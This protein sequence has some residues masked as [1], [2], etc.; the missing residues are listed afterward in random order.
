L[1]GFDNVFLTAFI[2]Q[3]IGLT[4]ILTKIVIYKKRRRRAKEKTE[5]RTY[6]G[7]ETESVIKRRNE[8][9]IGI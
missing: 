6:E 9:R 4:T 7:E 8:M 3:N 2:S 5:R 1:I